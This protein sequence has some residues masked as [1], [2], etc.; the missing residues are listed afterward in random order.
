MTLLNAGLAIAGLAAISIPILI[1]LLSR[2]RRRPVEWAAMRFLIEAFRKHR[3][4]LRLEQWLLLAARCL[5]VAL[6]GL[7]LARP[8]LQGGPLID[9]G[10][11]RAVYL[12]IDDSM[13]SGLTGEDSRTA[14]ARHVDQAVELVKALGAGDAVGLVTASRPSAA[15]LMPASTDKASVIELLEGLAP[16]QTPSDFA[17]AFGHLRSVIQ[18]ARSTGKETLVYLFSEFRSGSAALDA[19]LPELQTEAA[20]PV[21][22]LAS[23]PAAHG[24]SNVQI[25][26][27][28]PVRSLILPGANDGS[29]QVT[30]RLRRSGAQLGAEVTRVRLSGEGLPAIGAKTVQWSPGDSEADVEFMLELAGVSDREVALTASIDHDA[31]I[32]DNQRHSVLELRARIRTLL[33]DRRSFGFERALDRLSAGQWL[34]RAIEPRES[35]PLQVVEA[36][37]AAL[38]AADIRG[39]DAAVLPRPDLLGESGWMAL[40]ELVD[41]GGLLLV[42]P[43]ADENVHQW[44][45]RF[46]AAM[47]LPWR[48][49]LA[50]RPHEPA[51]SLAEQQPRSELLRLIASELG[52]LSRPVRVERS[53]PVSIEGETGAHSEVSLALSDGSPML[54]LAAPPAMQPEGAGP[55]GRSVGETVGE[56]RGMVAY[57]AVA[58]EVSWTNLPTQT[59]M[60][61]LIHETIRNGLSLIRASQRIVVGEQPP[62]V[63]GRG[64]RDLQSPNGQRV[65]LNPAGR[66]QAALRSAGIWSVL[67]RSGQPIS[68]VAAN[69]DPDAGVTQVQSAAAVSNW[70]KESGPW[71]VFAEDAMKASL[72]SGAAMSPIAGM[73]LIALLALA[74]VETLLAR[75]FSHAYRHE[76]VGENAGGLRPTI[77][78]AAASFRGA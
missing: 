54:I 4:R 23:A 43:P 25:V 51:L 70:L 53:L 19:S 67:D 1:H 26:A 50:T 12:V 24:A 35:S 47:S 17:G 46:A 28:E 56:P 60:V 11:S 13:A 2:Q 22:L 62:I 71:G 31:L 3:R 37:P 14:L 7:A 73:L 64:A 61:P 9:T 38:D 66:P 29:G 27:I 74:I 77:D 72:S 57:L 8:M 10:S 65:A 41:R 48:F 49:A 18:D 6:L 76:G 55:D 52:E 78:E 69:V 75:S 5:I 45:E 30:V 36:D 40:R 20:D 63:R 59:L 68:L 34:R 15:R 58:P 21:R 39:A 33:I 16:S 44:A 32:A 42:T